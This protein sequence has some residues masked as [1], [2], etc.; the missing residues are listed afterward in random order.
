MDE[1]RQQL[2]DKGHVEMHSH[3]MCT[4][5]G[6]QNASVDDIVKSEACQTFCLQ[7]GVIGCADEY[8]DLITFRKL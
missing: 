3:A 6:I 7:E 2:K 5:L 1:F 4:L 8:P